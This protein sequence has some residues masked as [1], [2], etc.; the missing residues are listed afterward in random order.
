MKIWIITSSNDTLALFNFLTKYDHE[1]VIYYDF[2]QW[3]YGDKTFDESLLAVQRWVDFLLKKK[4]DALI[5][6]PLYELALASTPKILPL[7]ADYVL[8]E[9]FAHSLVGKIGLIGDF[10]DMQQGQALMKWLEKKYTLNQNQQAIKKFQRPFAYRKKEVQ[11]RKYYL[12]VLSYSDFMVNKVIKFDL[13]YFKDAMVDTVIPCNYGY[14]HYQT[15][16]TKFFNF[17]KIKFHKLEKL[18]AIFQQL[19][20]SMKL[21]AENKKYSVQVFFTGHA[22]F[23]QREKRLM[24]L[25]QRG[26]SVEVQFE[27][28]K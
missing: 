10:A 6:P 21:K 27:E 22:E 4:V 5:V 24:R 18:E 23:L 12:S 14:F 25:L 7:F 9:C 3:P 11:L 28:V 17:K 15:T 2:A 20:E 8:K 19:A 1:Y 26:K 13:R 16:I